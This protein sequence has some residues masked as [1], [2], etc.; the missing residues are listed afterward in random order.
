MTDPGEITVLV[1]DADGVLT[2]G[3]IIYSDGGREFQ[4][5]SSRDGF[6]L[7][8][9]RRAGLRAAVITGRGG[10]A[11]IRRMNE[12]G[13]GHVVQGS[14]NKDADLRALAER[15][16]VPL[17]ACAYVGDDWPDI[18][19]MKLAGY[20]IAVADAEPAV[21]EAADWVTRRPGGRGAVRDAVDHLLSARGQAGPG[22][23]P[24]VP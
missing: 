17:D 8:R 7:Q 24:A 9:W 5:F 1:L 22:D 11:L 13:V 15:L 10:P 6:G 14:K 21:I 4:R 20:A 3:S 23:D 2:D 18:A 12:L 16:G 19:A